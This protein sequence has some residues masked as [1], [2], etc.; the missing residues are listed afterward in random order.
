MKVTKYPQSC[1]LIEKSGKRLLID[2]GVFVAQ[3]FTAHEFGVVDAVLI[4]HEHADHLHTELLRAVIADRDIPVV[5]NESAAKL[6]EGMVTKVVRDGELFEVA[7]FEIVAHELPHCAM[8]D[9]GAGPQ[10]TGYIVD[11]TFF[12]PGDGVEVSGVHVPAAGVAIAGPDISP[13]DVV[14][15]IK[16]VGC[17]TVIP[18]HY[19]NDVFHGLKDAPVTWAQW[20]GLEDVKVVPLADGE[21]VELGSLGMIG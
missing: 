1:L 13:R 10:N 8:V 6:S 14:S 16:S 17:K 11:N 2:P 7:G 21:S 20:G 18:L 5:A 15:F 12:D 19:T 9:G 3:K 4:T